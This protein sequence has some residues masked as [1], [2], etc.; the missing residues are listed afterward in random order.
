MSEQQSQQT[1]V[2]T[3]YTII[4]LLTEDDHSPV[5]LVDEQQTK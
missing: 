4:D 1:N 2:D 5:L 3:D